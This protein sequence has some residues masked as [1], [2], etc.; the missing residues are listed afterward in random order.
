VVGLVVVLWHVV[1]LV[2][3]CAE[4]VLDDFVVVGGSLSCGSR[5]DVSDSFCWW[6]VVLALVALVFSPDD[7]VVD[8]SLVV[9]TV[10]VLELMSEVVFNLLNIADSVVRGVVLAEVVSINVW[11]LGA[12]VVMLTVVMDF[13][14]V[15]VGS[16]VFI[17][18]LIELDSVRVVM[19]AALSKSVQHISNMFRLEVFSSM[20]L[21]GKVLALFINACFFLLV[22]GF[23]LMWGQAILSLSMLKSVMS[24]LNAINSSF[25]VSFICNSA[26]TVS[27]NI[28]WMNLM[29]LVVLLV[30]SFMWVGNNM[31]RLMIRMA[32][33][34]VMLTGML[35]AISMSIMEG[36]LTVDLS[37]MGDGTVSL[38]CIW[39]NK[40][41]VFM[42]LVGLLAVVLSDE[43]LFAVFV[44]NSCHVLVDS[45]ENLSN[46]L[47]EAFRWTH[48]VHF[49]M[50]GSSRVSCAVVNG[51]VT[52][53]KVVSVLV[54]NW[55]DVSMRRWVELVVIIMVR[56]FVVDMGVPV[57]LRLSAV[58]GVRMIIMLI[59]CM[60]LIVCV[61]VRLS[62]HGCDWMEM[63]RSLVVI[64]IGVDWVVA[65]VDLMLEWGI[66]VI[67]ISVMVFKH[68]WVGRGS[69][70]P[71]VELGVVVGMLLVIIV[72]LGMV[73]APLVVWDVV[74]HM[75]L[76][77]SVDSATLIV[78]L[79]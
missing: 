41:E 68:R 8:I 11:V 60:P 69:W 36:G 79:V 4:A 25:T 30:P 37:K 2:G 14:V 7:V 77:V 40:L 34:I 45:I 44:P 78:R 39:V 62:V 73:S 27:E 15:C 23:K 33:G 70:V 26:V 50:H 76:M 3:L 28:G 59:D 29:V 10:Q 17:M 72:S 71:V 16:V 47:L 66:K 75:S 61:E 38:V 42:W 32:M 52:M 63:D 31:V 1:L 65:V 18:V 54:I 19:V 51:V 58:M 20:M 24:V 6:S 49:F 56:V 46:S 9:A 64:V 5:V 13:K 67:L 43:V 12:R 21:G 35:D 53:H 55:S 74:T 57:K 22:L 48:L